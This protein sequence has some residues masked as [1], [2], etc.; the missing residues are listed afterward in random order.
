MERIHATVEITSA[1]EKKLTRRSAEKNHFVH[2]CVCMGMG[3]DF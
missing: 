3:V 1:I 2:M